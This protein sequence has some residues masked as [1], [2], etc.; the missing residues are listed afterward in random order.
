MV[1]SFGLQVYVLTMEGETRAALCDD[2]GGAAKPGAGGVG[3]AVSAGTC[4]R[5]RWTG[6]TASALS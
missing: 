5:E 3:L 6:T 1:D 2:D 4:V